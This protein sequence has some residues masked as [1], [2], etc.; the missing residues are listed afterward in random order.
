MSIPNYS[1]SRRFD[2]KDPDGSIH[3]HFKPYVLEALS[4]LPVAFR[5]GSYVYN[6]RS[7]GK[8]PIFDL[9]GITLSPPHPGPYAGAPLGG[10]G[11]GAIGRGFKGEFR[12]WSLHPGRYHH[13]VVI[14][15]LFAIRVKRRNGIHC[16]VLSL[17]KPDN[18]RSCLSSW[19]WS[20]SPTC[21]TYH[22]LFPLAWTVYEEPVPNLRVIV[23]QLSP[24]LP[25]DYGEASLPVAC[26]SI[27]VENLSSSEDAEVSIMFSFQNGCE[28]HDWEVDGDWQHFPFE[29]NDQSDESVNA[30]G[31]C[32]PSRSRRRVLSKT[33]AGQPSSTSPCREPLIS[34]QTTA[35]YIEDQ[36]QNSGYS[37]N[38]CSQESTEEHDAGDQTLSARKLWSNF[39]ELG[40]ICDCEEELPSH[41]TGMIYGSAVCL[42]KLIGKSPSK[43]KANSS[44]FNFS[45]A[46]DHPVARFG[47][48]LGLP[49]FYTRF[50]GTA[51]LSAPLLACYALRRLK[52]WT[53]RIKQWQKTV[54][55][56]IETNAGFR[57]SK[58]ESK[59]Y[60]AQVFNELYYLVDGGTLWTDSSDG[61]SNQANRIDLQKPVDETLLQYES[62]VYSQY[63]IQ[64]SRGEVVRQRVDQVGNE[65]NDEN[66]K[67]STSSGRPIN[68]GPLTIAPALLRSL[69]QTMTQHSVKAVD[70]GGDQRVVGQ[71]LYLEGQE[72]LMYNTYDVHF[73]AAF[74][75]LKLWP[76]LELSLQRDFAKAVSVE[77]LEVR[78]MMG[79]GTYCERKAKDCLPHDLGSPSEEPWRFLNAYNFQD[80]SRWK[81]LG[82][83]F[84][85]SVYRDYLAT[86]SEIFLH[87]LYP[88]AC[89]IMKA[90]L[91]YDTDGDGM[92]ENSGFPDQTYDI[93]T[94]SGVTAYC[95]GLW[96]A[97]CEAMAAIAAIMRDEGLVEKYRNIAERARDV[98]ISVLWNGSFLR[99]DSSTSVYHD[100]IQ[101]DM[102]AGHCFTLACSLPPVLPPAKALS[103]LRTIYRYN[104]VEFGDG[105]W[106]GAVNGMRPPSS[107]SSARV[108]NSC[109]QS[110]E[111]WTGTTYALA[112]T[113]LL[114]ARKGKCSESEQEE[115]LT[116]AF[117]TARGI[118]DAG[119]QEFGYWFATPEAWFRNG[120]YRSMGYMRPLA[121]W[122]MQYALSMD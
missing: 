46:W 5:V 6:E 27:E 44:E 82:P 83:K 73:T 109:L 119:W 33:T 86:K 80:V 41:Q 22:A 4:L 55:D 111:V 50:F 36:E 63:D 88:T 69:L 3:T 57:D 2:E 114:Q 12:R 30:K 49:R 43:N 100:S 87:D 78:R 29:M 47:G 42:R 107:T 19:D 77:D 92:I 120:N 72:Y 61:F 45:L 117:N 90:M 24:F 115:L 118:H 74:A 34:E 68:G 52:E 116:M 18:E 16:K 121:V 104:V 62:Y 39:H 51:G 15:D 76:Q 13:H 101:A 71:F 89:V 23:K 95:G 14:A 10:L 11:G 112:A 84:I 28:Q 25:G 99:Y 66:I 8:E 56:Q 38:F 1:W 105:K 20:L 113:M 91:L 17:H 7:N 108:D 110:R 26:F 93:W 32:M 48:G 65:D 53:E 94:A 97:A 70:C 54:I 21:G 103:C 64:C 75:L 102:L 37:F 31:I 96:I 122:A 59:Y 81:D 35:T 98:Y 60:H 79:E 85:L 58:N 9:N 106:L 40:D 67:F